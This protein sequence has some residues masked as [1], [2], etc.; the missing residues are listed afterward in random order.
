ML[1]RLS[2]AFA[3]CPLLVSLP[4]SRRRRPPSEDDRNHAR[5]VLAGS[6]RLRCEAP[7]GNDRGN[8]AQAGTPQRMRHSAQP[9]PGAAC[10]ANQ[11]SQG[12]HGNGMR[13]AGRHEN[14]C[15]ERSRRLAD[16]YNEAGQLDK[17]KATVERALAVK[18]CSGRSRGLLV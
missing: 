2:I 1:K 13:G 18:I 7:A 3:C 14:S 10:R 9:D 11:S 16:L 8:N 5:R 6:A 12:C 15:R 4:F 17:M